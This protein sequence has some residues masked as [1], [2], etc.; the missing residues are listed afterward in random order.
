MGNLSRRDVLMVAAGAVTGATG[1]FQTT[2]TSAG[3]TVSDP[4]ADLLRQINA[5]YAKDEQEDVIRVGK[6]I[7]DL[8]KYGERYRA[9][10]SV[11]STMA[12]SVAILGRNAEKNG[13]AAKA[14]AMFK[15]AASCNRAYADALGFWYKDPWWTRDVAATKREIA[16][17]QRLYE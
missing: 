13:D 9:T 11:Y 17:V 10:A 8:D 12:H 6:K 3:D 7:E 16:K 14:L 15:R 4:V 5:H 1:L 2:S